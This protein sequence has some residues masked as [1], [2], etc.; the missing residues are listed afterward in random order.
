MRVSLLCFLFVILNCAYVNLCAQEHLDID[1]ASCRQDPAAYSACL[2]EKFNNFL[3]DPDFLDRIVPASLEEKFS[4]LSLLVP[5]MNRQE[6]LQSACHLK[7]LH[8]LTH[9]LKEAYENIFY[10]LEL[11]INELTPEDTSR[12][13][14]CVSGCGYLVPTTFFERLDQY[15]VKCR[16]NFSTSL[17]LSTL[18]HLSALQKG[19]AFDRFVCLFSAIDDLSSPNDIHNYIFLKTYLSEARGVSVVPSRGVRAA[20]K[21]Y[22]R[23]AGYSVRISAAQ[24]EVTHFIRSFDSRFSSEVFYEDLDIH[25]DIAHVKSR[26]VVDMDGLHHYK[27]NTL[28]AKYFRRPLDL[29]RDAVLQKRGWKIYRI[30]IDEWDH[31]KRDFFSKMTEQNTLDTFYRLYAV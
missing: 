28:S 19:K 20:L 11:S 27:E 2:R 30:R 21:R 31:F 9:S 13:W 10:M 25:L 29:M 8:F 1:A 26:I 18:Q 23:D 24:Q 7:R 15:T 3:K 14:S 4:E 6:L 5:R 17:V 22:R 16:R 12:V